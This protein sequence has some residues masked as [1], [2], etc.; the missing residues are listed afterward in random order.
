MQC[1]QCIGAKIGAV[2]GPTASGRAQL[3]GTLFGNN[4]SLSTL[5]DVRFDEMAKQ[6]DVVV[7]RSFKLARQCMAPM[8]GKGALG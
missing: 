5:M 6:T 8:E 4:P 7:K 3:T 1:A 2:I